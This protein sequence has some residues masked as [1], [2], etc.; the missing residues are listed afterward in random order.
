LV[1][2]IRTP[3]SIEDGFVFYPL[4]DLVTARSFLKGSELPRS[5][6]ILDCLLTVACCGETLTPV[7]SPAIANLCGT[8][9]K[10]IWS[11]K[12]Q[13]DALRFANTVVRRILRPLFE[14]ENRDE[15]VPVALAI[16]LCH[17]S[18][19]RTNSSRSST[20]AN[21]HDNVRFTSYKLDPSTHLQR[22]VK[23]LS[24]CSTPTSKKLIWDVCYRLPLDYLH[25]GRT[26]AEMVYFVPAYHFI[27]STEENPGFRHLLYLF[28]GEAI[29]DL[30]RV[31]SQ[32]DQA[33]GI[34]NDEE[35]G[36]SIPPIPTSSIEESE[37]DLSLNPFKQETPESVYLVD[38]RF[39]P[40]FP[41]L[42]IEG[43]PDVI[44]CGIRAPAIPRHDTPATPS[45]NDSQQK[46]HMVVQII[47]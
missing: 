21:L 29:H 5:N 36:E 18:A 40:P 6:R 22:F 25:D 17:G 14:T 28:Q 12:G 23:V 9:M 15:D 32:Y 37:V 44:N 16:W 31:I 3:W 33:Q 43:D 27:Y 38:F 47:A 41:Q 24:R 10:S 46:L 19:R 8:W 30:K 1:L 2:S 35:N 26:P 42:G 34:A 39:K 20:V 13:T 11:I 7:N 45:S 4:R